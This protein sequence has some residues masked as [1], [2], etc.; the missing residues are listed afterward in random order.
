MSS[1][2]QVYSNDKSSSKQRS[3]KPVTENLH[4]Q[5]Q[6]QIDS[7]SFIQRAKLNPESLTPRDLLQ[8]QRIIGNQATSQLLAGTVQRQSTQVKS[9]PARSFL[10]SAASLVKPLADRYEQEVET[11]EAQEFVTHKTPVLHRAG[12]GDLVLQRKIGF[13]FEYPNWQTVEASNKHFAAASAFPPDETHWKRIP[14]GKALVRDNGFELQADDDPG[15]G[16]R[17]DLEVVTKAFD[18]SPG[19]RTELR[20]T[21]QAIQNSL[22]QITANFNNWATA[23]HLP[24]ATDLPGNPVRNRSF[25]YPASGG[26][27]R[28]KP[29][30]TIGLSLDKIADLLEDIF[31]APAETLGQ[32]ASR[33]EGRR[34]L[35]GWDPAAAAAGQIMTT[36]GEA[37]TQA[38]QAIAAY[39]GAN[40]GAPALSNELVGLLSLIMAYLRMADQGLV[41]SYAK[42]IAPVM[43]RTDFG[44]MFKMLSQ[45]EQNW[46]KAHSGQPLF[47]LVSQAPWFTTM[48]PADEV[49]SQGIAA[50]THGVGQAQGL[51]RGKWIKGIASGTDY[52][53]GKKFP[54]RSQ[55]GDIE[56]LG[57][58]GKK[59]DIVDLGGGQ[60]KKTPILELRAMPRIDLADLADV[61][62]KIFVYTY[63]ANRGVAYKYGQH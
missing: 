60:T 39:T 13:E 48:A 54:D 44:A 61:A 62:E 21:M 6:Q 32:A 2:E 30:T 36:Q 11:S 9:R 51:S 15:G 28:A 38:R 56:G 42:T 3:P 41:R 23:G 31:A 53:T 43:A 29:Q 34:E 57:A 5:A 24:R 7:A 26:E 10:G 22:G 45:P 14:K 25:L 4:M 52:L 35:T 12:S 50:A 18:E 46:Y 33:R 40:A 17:S 55:R 19:G 8:L 49:F 63:L 16:A 47:D 37:P 27:F 59:S 20:A 58:Y 1:K